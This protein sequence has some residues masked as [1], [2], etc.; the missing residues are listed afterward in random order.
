V[1]V[2]F[3]A[4]GWV[5]YR[6]W[7]DGDRRIFR[8]LNHV[9]EDARRAPFDGTGKPERLKHVLAGCWARRITGEHR[10]VY[11]V[12]TLE[13]GATLVVLQCRHHY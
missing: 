2:T 4:D 1:N 11:M 6:F 5:D 12:R 13:L 10:L 7:A 8:R 9:I 3:T